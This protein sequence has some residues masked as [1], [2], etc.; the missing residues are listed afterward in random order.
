MIKDLKFSDL[1]W[2]A[3]QKGSVSRVTS[4]WESSGNILGWNPKQELD[5]N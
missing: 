3:K 5:P 2:W 4:A 1:K